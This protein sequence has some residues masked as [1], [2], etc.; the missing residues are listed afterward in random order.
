MKKIK[1]I[2]IIFL[3]AVAALPSTVFATVINT[4]TSQM[5]EDEKVISE[6]LFI[7]SNEKIV[8][9]REKAVNDSVNSDILKIMDLAYEFAC[10]YNQEVVTRVSI[11]VYGN[12]CGPK[13]GSGIPID[14]LDEGCKRH[15]ECY[16]KRGYHKC[17]CDRELA[18]YIEKNLHRMSGP[19][20]D[21]AKAVH[22]WADK[23]GRTVTEKGGFFSCRL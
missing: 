17:S 12:Y 6:Y 5:K 18:I 9:N 11:P 10:S 7:D 23:K 19:Q 3:I 22:Y 4:E 1:K 14:I 16:K 2:C 21:A 20:K 15:D 13:Y 8:Y